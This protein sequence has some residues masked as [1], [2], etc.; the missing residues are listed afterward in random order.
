V[1]KVGTGGVLTEKY[2]RARSAA[3]G[4]AVARSRS[5]QSVRLGSSVRKR[6]TS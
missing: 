3:V 6:S 2:S 5:A 4:L 1:K